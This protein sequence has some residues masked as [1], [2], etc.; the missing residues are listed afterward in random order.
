MFYDHPLLGLY[1]LGDASDGS[2][3]GQLAFAGTGFC[4]GA[5][6]PGNLNAFPI[7]QGLQNLPQCAPSIFPQANAN[8]GYLPDQQQFQALNFPQSVFLNQS[9]LNLT[10]SNPTF[11]PLGFQPF[12][13]PQS[14][15][16]VY[17]YS[18]QANL[19]VERD[20]GGGFALS[21][22]YNFNGGR[23]LNRPIN[24]N[25]IR[26]DLMVANFN[27]ALAAG[28]TPASPFTVSGCGV[29]PTGTPYVDA[30]LMNFFRPG[31]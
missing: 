26:G 28:Q 11:L 15:N 6:N 14:K 2:S 25:T 18:Q 19:T 29:T 20:L 24:A 1:F 17:A 23:H 22:A 13:Y 27:A 10:S 16:F 8:L 5:G 12:G 7:F 31:A 3:S 21:L 4:S 30:S 9:Y